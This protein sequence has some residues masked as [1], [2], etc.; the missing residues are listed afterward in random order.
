MMEIINGALNGSKTA[1][2]IVAHLLA[3]ETDAAVSGKAAESNHGILDPRQKLIAIQTSYS[4]VSGQIR[5]L[6]TEIARLKDWKDE[7]ERYRLY[8]PVAD[9]LL[10][11][12]KPEM[13][14]GEPVHDLCPKCY[15][16]NI[17][18]ILQSLPPTNG[19]GEMALAAHD[20][21]SCT[22]KSLFAKGGY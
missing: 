22:F 1:F 12:V 19:G 3:L 14:K 2:E 10:Y 15:Q 8:E 20:V 4:A 6:E 11:R 16:D 7:K 5:N 17:N 21:F 13:Q 9:V 18:P